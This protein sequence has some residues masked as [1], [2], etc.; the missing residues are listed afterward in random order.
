LLSVSADAAAQEP[1]YR[2]KTVSLV[3][4]SAPGGGTDII[5]RL[6]SAAMEKYLP[7]QPNIVYKVM[8]AAGG[9]AGLN[10]FAAQAAPDGLTFFIGAGNQLSPVVLRR[11]EIKYDPTKFEIIGGFVNP[12]GYLLLRPQAVEQLTDRSAP[13][14]HMAVLDGTRSGDLLAM[15]GADALGWNI[16][17]VFGYTG[18]SSMSL[19]LQRGEVDAMSNNDL[20]V[21]MPMVKAGQATVVV[22]TGELDHGK[23]L[24]SRAF[25][26]PPLLTNLMHGKLDERAQAAFNVWERQSQIGK[27]FALPPGTPASHVK[28]Y[29]EAFRKAAAEPDFQ[30]RV[31]ATIAPD[32]KEMTAEDMISLIRDMVDAKND[33]LDYLDQLTS[34]FRK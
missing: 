19:A 5:A 3:V 9:T 8:P 32:I 2:G 23:I 17:L 16:S 33:S 18:T 26:E 15:W 28:V 22:Q 10:W 11:P 29:R 24:P 12:S 21:V 1:N 14:I 27:W 13:P 34:R 4:S 20:A 30:A 31:A 25:P 6:V 7:G